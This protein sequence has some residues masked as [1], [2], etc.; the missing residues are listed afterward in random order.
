LHRDAVAGCTD[1]AG[2][3]HDPGIAVCE[4]DAV[5]V[6]I[7]FVGDGGIEVEGGRL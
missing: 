6:V 1:K 5:V 4:H 2:R 7:V 3:E